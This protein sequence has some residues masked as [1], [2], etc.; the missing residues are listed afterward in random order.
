MPNAPPPSP[1]SSASAG[2]AV[3]RLTGMPPNVAVDTSLLAPFATEGFRAGSASGFVAARA[4]T[5]A[6]RRTAT[7]SDDGGACRWS[8]ARARR[9]SRACGASGR[10]RDEAIGR[11]RAGVQSDGWFHEG[12]AAG[13]GDGCR[14]VTLR[15]APSRTARALNALVTVVMVRAFRSTLFELWR[16][17]RRGWRAGPASA[18]VKFQTSLFLSARAFPARR[19]FA[20]V[21]VFYRM[22]K[23]PGF[24][25]APIGRGDSANLFQTTNPNDAQSSRQSSTRLG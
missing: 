11:R 1:P 6:G 17:G 3:A 2:S 19:A 10:A 8:A 22:S 20:R 15:G 24:C 9:S 18:N 7:C 4:V 13:V 12:G 23:S 5:R 25:A 14:R 16:R 21:L